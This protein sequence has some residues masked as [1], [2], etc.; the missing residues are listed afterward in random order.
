MPRPG[1]PGPRATEKSKDFKGSMLRL[2]KNLKP[3]KYIMGLALCLAMISAILSLIA[4]DKLSDLTDTITE[5]ISPN[6]EKLRE[7]GEAI[8][9][10]MASVDMQTKMDTLFTEVNMTQD[11]KIE[12]QNIFK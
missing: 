6:I 11:E 10:N 12:V 4:P 9:E 3:W 1:G 2:F 7:V 8:G 5:G